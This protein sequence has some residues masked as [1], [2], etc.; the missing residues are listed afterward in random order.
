[1]LTNIY[2]HTHIHTHTHICTNIHTYIHTQDGGRIVVISR[3]LR[4]FGYFG[5]DKI[6]TDYSKSAEIVL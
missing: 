3:E 5:L 4:C 6:S 2:I 1:M